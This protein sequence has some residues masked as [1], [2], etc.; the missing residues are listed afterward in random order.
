MTTVENAKESIEAC[1]KNKSNIATILS[2]LTIKEKPL[3]RFKFSETNKGKTIKLVDGYTAIMESSGSER[4][5]LMD[6]SL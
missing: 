6:P 2:C 5:I 1:I 3:L 4:M